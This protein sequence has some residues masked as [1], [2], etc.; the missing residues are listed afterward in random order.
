MTS[1]GMKSITATAPAS[2]SN[3]VSR[4]T[5]SLRYW[6]EIGG[7][8]ARW[9]QRHQLVVF[10]L[11]QQCRKAMRAPLSKR[12]Q[13]NADG[14]CSADQRRTGAVADQRVV[15]IANGASGSVVS[16]RSGGGNV[17][18]L[19]HQLQDSRLERP[20]YTTIVSPLLPELHTALP[21]FSSET[22]WRHRTTSARPRRAVTRLGAH[23]Y[24]DG[25]D[26]AGLWSL[27]CAASLCP[28]RDGAEAL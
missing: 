10:R 26:F 14:V 15:L 11:S 12:G 22:L 4:T 16:R 21:T 20:L 1:M 18:D 13:H 6:R 23:T 8:L 7:D 17:R 9:S 25:N 28:C 2:V 5:V 19:R 24:R 27:D 3:R